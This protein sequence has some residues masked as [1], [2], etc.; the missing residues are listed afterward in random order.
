MKNSKEYDKNYRE[1]NRDR[2]REYNTEYQR[3]KRGSIR[4]NI[5]DGNAADRARIKNR[6]RFRETRT[7]CLAHY[8]E[9]EIECKCCGENNVKFL[10]MDHINNDGAAHR[11]QLTKTGKGG[12]IYHWIK[13]NNFPSGFQ[14]LCFNCNSGKGI[15][16][17]CPHK[18][19]K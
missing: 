2:L 15:Y 6:D 8:G 12:N 17:V 5:T 13:R 11:R 7:E 9:G 1:E 18:I 10:T 19:D 14:I 16:G 3:K 4:I